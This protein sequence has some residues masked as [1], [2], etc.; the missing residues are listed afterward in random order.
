MA[1]SP[2][3]RPLSAVRQVVGQPQVELV[4]FGTEQRVQ[5][6]EV[7]GRLLSGRAAAASRPGDADRLRG[8]DQGLLRFP[9]LTHLQELHE[10]FDPS[11]PEPRLR[12]VFT[13][14]RDL[15]DRLQST[16][17]REDGKT[18]VFSFAQPFG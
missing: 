15:K 4:Q 9:D 3:T 13:T 6:L 17:N 14:Q 7:Q 18:T 11:L 16:G 8:A 1:Q 2:G 12:A 10:A 5:V